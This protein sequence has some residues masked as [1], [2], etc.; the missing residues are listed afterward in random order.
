MA[1]VLLGLGTNMGYRENNLQH[2]VKSWQMMPDTKVVK[3]SNVYETAPIGYTDQQ[4]FYNAVLLIETELSPGAVLGACLGMEASLGRKRQIKNG[5]R[6]IDI[7]VL[8]YENV[9]MDNHELTLPH[10]RMM[11]RRFVLEPLKEL[12]PDG[13][14]LGRYFNE[15]LSAVQDQKL[16]KTGVVI[17]L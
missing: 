4:N 15:A 3:C 7:D 17:D 14:V 9:K 12:F 6:V 1:R 16:V 8:M 10:P 11:E 2:I 13:K 5:P